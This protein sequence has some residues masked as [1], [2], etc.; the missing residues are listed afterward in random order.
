MPHDTATA[1]VVCVGSACQDVLLSVDS[2]PPVD[3]KKPVDEIT[4]QGGGP[5]ATASV[6]IARLGGRAALISAVGED[7]RGERILAELRS[8]GVDVSRCV[9]L[10]GTQST[11]AMI[12]VDR[13][14]GTR[15]IF[16]ASGP[17]DLPTSDVDAGLIAGA[18]VLLVD[19]HLPEA[20]MEACGIAR[21]AGVP[22]VLDAG[23]PKSA[24]NGLLDLADYPVPPL[25]SALRLTGTG[26][27]ESAAR[28][29]LR[30]RARG[31]VVTMGP[32]G[33]VV[34]TPDG[35]WHEPAF[36]VEAVDTTGA[37]DAFHG[38][39]ALAIARGYPVREA[40][41]FAAAVAAL[42][43]RMPGGRTGLP[44]LAEVDA[45]LASS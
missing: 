3:T 5:A 37:G 28:S 18:G 1:D 36:R 43:C 45:L 32:R 8:E 29:L 11:F 31:V 10:A 41:R 12:V 2:F 17:G 6:A 15:T 26:D 34:A 25:A 30:G 42:K 38:G 7:A 27:P 40:A 21:R 19:T 20:A 4:E 13:S 35:V 14:T 33:Y 22:V 44:T 23:E 24:I 39:F 9:R 16:Y